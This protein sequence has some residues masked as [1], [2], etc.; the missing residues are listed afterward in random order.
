MYYLQRKTPNSQPSGQQGPCEMLS[1][2]G[3]QNLNKLIKSWGESDEEQ[4]SG[5]L[6]VH[7]WTVPWK[8]H[9]G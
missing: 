1:R 5:L 4:L 8:E 9:C 3:I 2:V 7:G 6:A